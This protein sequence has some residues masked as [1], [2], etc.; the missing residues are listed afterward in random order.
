MHAPGAA[1]V[2]VITGTTHGIG[3]VLAHRL[4]RAG[5]QVVMLWRNPALPPPGTI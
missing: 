2:A 5:M 1:R 4:A 3:R